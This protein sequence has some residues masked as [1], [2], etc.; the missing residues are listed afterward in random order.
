MLERRG[1]VLTLSWARGLAASQHHA[2]PAPSDLYCSNVLTAAG[3]RRGSEASQ[4]VP[5]LFINQLAPSVL[6]WQEQG[7]Q[8]NLTSDMFGA[9]MTA[10]VRL[11]INMLGGTNHS[12]V[13]LK[14]RLPG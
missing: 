11:H 14:M 12:H 2:S 4:Q 3:C 13:I 5:E 1:S 9:N 8:L 10:H 7:L 6:T